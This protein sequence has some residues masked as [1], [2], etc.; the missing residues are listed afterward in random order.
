[1]VIGDNEGNCLTGTAN[2]FGGDAKVLGV[3]MRCWP[4]IPCVWPDKRL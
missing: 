4:L 2:L 3:S 1:V